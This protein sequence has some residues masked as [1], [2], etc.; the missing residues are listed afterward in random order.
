[1]GPAHFSGKTGCGSGGQ[2]DIFE[3][4]MTIA[5]SPLLL[6]SLSLEPTPGSFRHRGV[7]CSAVTLL[8]GGRRVSPRWLTDLDSRTKAR[9]CRVP[10]NVDFFTARPGPGVPL[11]FAGTPVKPELLREQLCPRNDFYLLSQSS[12]EP[13]GCREHSCCMSEEE[14]SCTRRRAEE[15]GDAQGMAV[16]EAGGGTQASLLPPTCHSALPG[17]AQI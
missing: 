3:G 16:W 6:E 8:M 17:P 5:S 7:H 13:R 9:K 4:R 14:T 1:M 10:L 11:C 12:Y 15:A 2:A